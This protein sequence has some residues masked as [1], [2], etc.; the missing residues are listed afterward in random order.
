MIV[1]EDRAEIKPYNYRTWLVDLDNSPYDA[2]YL[3]VPTPF[4]FLRALLHRCSL[5]TISHLCLRTLPERAA[6]LGYCR[7]TPFI[8]V[9]ANQHLLGCHIHGGSRP[10]GKSTKGTTW[11]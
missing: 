6:R 8:M 5:Y 4:L 7:W 1:Q 3:L 10:Y 11:G 9:P 2:E